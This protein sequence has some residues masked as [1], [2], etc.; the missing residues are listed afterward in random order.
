MG[1]ADDGALGPSWRHRQH[2]RT[3]EQI[4]QVL[5]LRGQEQGDDPNVPSC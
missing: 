2:S 3:Q 1:E 4:H 5:A